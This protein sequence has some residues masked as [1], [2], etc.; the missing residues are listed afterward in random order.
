MGDIDVLVKADP[1]SCRQAAA[2]LKRLAQGLDEAASSALKASSVSESFWEGEAADT[3][4]EQIFRRGRDV[5]ELVR[6]ADRAGSGLD[7]F[8]DEIDTVRQ[9]MNQCLQTAREAG[10]TVTGTLIH[11]PPGDASDTAPQGAGGDMPGLDPNAGA[12]AEAK[13][14]LDAFREIEATVDEERR[15]ERTA[16]KSLLKAMDGSNTVVDA[17]ADT[18]TW[19]ARSLSYAGTAHGEAIKLAQNAASQLKFASDF[20]QWSADSTLPAAVRE[21]HMERMLANVGMDGTAHRGQ[22][23][24]NADRVPQV[25]AAFA[26]LYG[27]HYPIAKMTTVEHYRDASDEASM[28]DDNTSA[29]NCR[30]IP[31]KHKWSQHAFGRAVDINPLLNPQTDSQGDVQ[32]ITATRYLDRNQNIPGLIHDG[33]PVVRMFTTRGWTWGGHWTDPHDYQHFEMP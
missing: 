2:Y 23:V 28:E 4:R 15:R 11:Q 18:Q 1:A 31:G 19:I 20:A 13:R 32:P 24:V 21:A 3:F 27:M 9:R 30:P 25:V 16:H 14:K 17:V 6:A 29:F 12:H 26:Q 33:D 22:L 7:F 5:D 10:L 8:A